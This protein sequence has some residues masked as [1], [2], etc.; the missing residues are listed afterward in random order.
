MLEF[1]CS[2]DLIAFLC[3]N[4]NVSDVISN[5]E[6]QNIAMLKFAIRLKIKSGLA[7]SFQRELV[8]HVEM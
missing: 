3:K 7:K 1:V 4:V 2:L 8:M 5:Y 6:Q